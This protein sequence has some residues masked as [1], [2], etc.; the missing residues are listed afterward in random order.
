MFECVAVA[1][2]PPASEKWGGGAG[3]APPLSG[4][5]SGEARAFRAGDV[6]GEERAAAVVVGVAVVTE[7]VAA[8]DGPAPPAAGL[9]AG[10][11]VSA[12][13]AGG[14][15]ESPAFVVAVVSSLSF[16]RRVRFGSSMTGADC[17]MRAVQ[18]VMSA[19]T[20]AESSAKR[21]ASGR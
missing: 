14:D 4:D 11:F 2:D 10:D 8:P 16:R 19:E 21:V 20:V 7:A 6:C 13:A 9:R 3:S 5:R 17:L 15:F 12:A 18:W 1:I